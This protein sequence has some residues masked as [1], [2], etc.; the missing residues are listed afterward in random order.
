MIGNAGG[1]TLISNV[2][3]TGDIYVSGFGYVGGIV[4]HGYPDIYN[5]SVEANEGSYI[6]GTGFWCVGGIIGY[7]GEDGTYIKDCSV[8]GVEIWSAQGGAGAVAGLLQYGN[9]LENVHAQDVEVTSSSDYAMGYIAG[10]GGESTYINVTMKN[11]T[12]T[13]NGAPITNS[14]NANIT[15]LD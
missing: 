4:G 5:C 11:V 9:K 1:N 12:A 8:S 13:A 2:K 3:L 6:H 14:D 10:N 15:V 7:A